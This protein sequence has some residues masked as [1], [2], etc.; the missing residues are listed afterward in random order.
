MSDNRRRNRAIKGALKQLY[1]TEPTG[2]LAR[3][4][5]T[6]AMLIGGIVGSQRVNLPAIA[7]KAPNGT[8]R[9]SQV[10]R[11]ERWVDNER[12]DLELYYLPFV[13]TLLAGL[14]TL[15]PLVLIMDGSEVGRNCMTLMLS[16]LYQGRALPLVWMV[17]QGKKGHFPE[18]M[19]VELVA[20][21]Q[22][23]LPDKAEVVFLG[24]GEFDGPDLLAT[25]AAQGW[26]YVCRTGKNILLGVDG[27]WFPMGEVDLIR[28]Q[29]LTMPD[30]LFTHQGLGPVL[31]ILW[32]DAAYKAPIYLVTNMTA[33]ETA[34]SW[35]RKRA[36]IET[37]FSDQKS[38]GFRLDK[39]HIANPQRLARL[40]IAACLAYLWIIF[41]GALALRD[42]WMR[43]I[44]R[45]RRCD[46]SLFQ[47]GLTLLDHL[48][49]EG[50]PIPVD[51]RLPFQGGA[52]SVR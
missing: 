48:L 42:G 4:L 45:A 21:L 49:N 23:L 29:R 9:E 30:V 36:R 8:K 13:S 41:L 25:I 50:L 3:H 46:L 39:S 38:R 11:F 15:G 17:R 20:Q 1:P 18:N 33:V 52:K 27:E 31:V 22:S 35:Y 34:C 16:V 24:D 6:L 10:K 7:S 47:L 14:A 37:F 12:I 51:F 5:S 19:H 28:G 40:M 2:N 44:H 32:W 43:T 26:Q